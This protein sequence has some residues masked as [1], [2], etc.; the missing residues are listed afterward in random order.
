MWAPSSWSEYWSR[1]SWGLKE[2][3]LEFVPVQKG[4]LVSFVRDWR[5]R[6]YILLDRADNLCTSCIVMLPVHDTIFILHTAL[7][8]TYLT[9]TRK[10]GTPAFDCHQ[11]LP[12]TRCTMFC[13][14]DAQLQAHISSITETLPYLPVDHLVDRLSTMSRLFELSDFRADKSQF[15]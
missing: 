5:R 10:T 9:M 7:S 4:S 15:R 12:V 13:Y 8:S 14:P 2:R 1:W 11:L 6:F 3:F